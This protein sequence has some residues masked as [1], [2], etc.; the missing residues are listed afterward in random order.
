MC[1]RA[2]ACVFVRVL[3]HIYV[4][5]CK[6]DRQKAGDGEAETDTDTDT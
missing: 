4:G 6:T 1:V 5:L 3:A 2:R